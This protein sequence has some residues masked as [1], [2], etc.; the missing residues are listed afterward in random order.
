M[1]HHTSGAGRALAA[2]AL[3][4]V[5]TAT[6]LGGCAQGEDVTPASDE[7]AGRAQSGNPTPGRTPGGTA[8]SSEP[9]APPTGTYAD[10]QYTAS[11]DYGVV[12]DIIEEDSIDVTVTLSGGVITDITVTGH[13]LTDRS[14]EYIQGFVDQIHGA[15]VGRS[16]EDAHVTA[17]AGAS[18]TS[19]AFNDAIDD[20]AQQAARAGV[21]SPED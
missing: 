13:G 12:D 14:R 11:E 2:G 4:T 3:L 7:Y 18:K 17:L 1:T 21:A 16:V 15:V 20:I 9:A 8:A 6:L 5:S 10:G 19:E